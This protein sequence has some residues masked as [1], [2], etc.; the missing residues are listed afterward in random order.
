MSMSTGIFGNIVSAAKRESSPFSKHKNRSSN[1]NRRGH[2]DGSLTPRSAQGS[3]EDLKSR[4]Q[5]NL[6]SVKP[7]EKCTTIREMDSSKDDGVL[8]P[9][10]NSVGD[11]GGQS[12]DFKNDNS[13]S[14]KP[15]SP[16]CDII[17]TIDETGTSV[18]NDVRPQT[19]NKH[20][21]PT[22]GQSNIPSAQIAISGPPT[23]KKH[24]GVRL[25][26]NKNPPEIIIS[27]DSAVVTIEPPNG[28]NKN[29]QG[30]VN[31]SPPI[32]KKDDAH[33]VILTSTPLQSTSSPETVR[34]TH[35]QQSE[36]VRSKNTE[37]TL[38]HDKVRSHTETPGDGGQIKPKAASDLETIKSTDPPK[39]V[40]HKSKDPVA[41]VCEPK[42]K[43]TPSAHAVAR[44]LTN[45][46]QTPQVTS[47]SPNVIP[48]IPISSSPKVLNHINT[49]KIPKKKSPEPPPVPLVSKQ[50]AT[51][52]TSTIVMPKPTKDNGEK[53]ATKPEPT[54][55]T[56]SDKK[57]KEAGPPV[58]DKTC[59]KTQPSQQ[60]PDVNIRDGQARPPRLSVRFKSEI[61]E[62][63]IE[64]DSPVCERKFKNG[65]RAD[66]TTVVTNCDRV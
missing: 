18:K 13:R 24:N 35:T 50:K 9:L 40:L 45:K 31:I 14:S 43:E 56:V 53:Q 61:E 7:R 42:E 25:V 63:E 57:E 29:T 1:Q 60:T 54:K 47:A 65:S 41:N 20:N 32:K 4:S 44:D 12:K 17:V 2:R 33:H 3:M 52:G 46:Q 34:N 59:I 23:D 8:E 62:N 10:V 37:C 16:I 51:P 55:H 49:V 15:P 27:D 19:P 38:P 11:S 6:L 48:L 39:V 36:Q 66:V 30:S 5:E 64:Q 28:V 26:G 58:L 21:Q 22:N